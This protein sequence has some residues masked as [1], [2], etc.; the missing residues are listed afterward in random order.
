MITAYISSFTPLPYLKRG[1]GFCVYPLLLCALLDRLYGKKF[2]LPILRRFS[3]CKTP[4]VV[5]KRCV[6]TIRC[7]PSCAHSIFILCKRSPAG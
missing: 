2:F 5:D 6:T 7:A 1:S 3:L 4:Q